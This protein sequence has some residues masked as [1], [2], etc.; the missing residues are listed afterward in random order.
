MS[1]EEE[2][3]ALR[4]QLESLQRAYDISED[5]VRTLSAGLKAAKE[6]S[7]AELARLREAGKVLAEKHSRVCNQ[8]REM[9]EAR[10]SEI[11]VTRECSTCR[12]RRA[13]P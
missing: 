12:A 7:E 3:R 11:K 6:E 8:L 5:I 9:T 2:V 1:A 10:A 4:G 13:L